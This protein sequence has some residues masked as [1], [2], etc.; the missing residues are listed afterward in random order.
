[1]RD[2]KVALLFCQQCA[3]LYDFKKIGVGRRNTEEDELWIKMAEDAEIEANR[4]AAAA[5]MQV[6]P[7]SLSAE[8]VRGWILEQQFNALEADGFCS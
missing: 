7:E 2:A 1:M 5:A 6:P 3:H 4:V 8:Q